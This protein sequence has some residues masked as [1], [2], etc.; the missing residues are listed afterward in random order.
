MSDTKPQDKSIQKLTK[1]GGKS[2]GVTIPIE[3]VRELG[4]REKQKVVVKRV[5]GGMFI[6]D[7]S[8]YPPPPAATKHNGSTGLFSF[9]ITIDIVPVL[10]GNLE[11]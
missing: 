9:C 6:S 8:L 7:D 5:R 11:L 1:L 4:W 10:E 2:I 3:L